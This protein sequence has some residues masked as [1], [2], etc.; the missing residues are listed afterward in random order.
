[1]K[2]RLRAL[3]ERG[4]GKSDVTF[5]SLVL[6]AILQ[7]LGRRVLVSAAP[8]LGNS[9]QTSF[10]RWSTWRGGDGLV[11]RVSLRLLVMVTLCVASTNALVGV[12]SQVSRPNIVF[13]L[14]DD[15]GY[16]DLSCQNPSSRIRTPRLDRLAGEGVRFTDAHAPSALCTPSRYSILTGQHCWRSRLKSGVANMWDEPL[17]APERMTVADLLHNNGYRTGFFGKWHLG[18]SWPFVGAVPD[19]FDINVTPADI[20]W[21]RRI[22]GGPVD[23]GFD[24]YFGINLANQPPYAFIENDHI[25]G[26]P[27]VQYP[28]ATGQQ[29]HWSG[30]GV[31]N[32]DWTQV[33]PQINSNTVR[34][35]QSAGAGSQPFFLYASLVGPHQPV[36]PSA[37]FQQTSQAGIYGDYV[38]EIDWAVGELLDALEATG[39]ATNT[40]VIFTSDNGPDEF[41]YARLQRYQHASMGELR[42]IKSDIWE[43]GHRVPFLARWPGQISGGTTNTQTICL[44]D[45]M[46]TVAD[47]LGVQLPAN[48][49]ED[50]AS[51]LSTLLGT[52]ANSLINTTHVTNAT[53][54]LES[55]IGQFGIRSNNWMYID[56]GTGDGHDPELEPLWFKQARQYQSSI[57]TP[58]LLYDL[59]ND[60][61]QRTNLLTAQPL[62]ASQL[63]AELTHQRASLSWRGGFS[64]AWDIADNWVPVGLPQGADILYSNWVGLANLNQTLSRAFS[65]NSI[66]LDTS[67]PADVRITAGSCGVLTIA[68]GIDMGHASVNLSIEAPLALS[69]SQVWNMG[70]GHELAVGGPVGIDSYRLTFCGSGNAR[71]TN[72][73]T[74]SGGLVIRSSGTT[75]LDARNLFTGG[76]E[77][78]GGGV[79][80]ARNN[81]A[82]GTGIL[83]IPN[84]STLEIDRGITLTNEA[85]VQGFGAKSNGVSC[86]AISMSNNGWAAYNGQIKLSADAALRADSPDSRLSIGGV[87]SGDANLTIMAGSGAIV[88][89]TNQSYTGKTLI[90]GQVELSGGPDRLPTGTDLVF[91]NASSAVLYLNGNNQTV[92]SISGGGG[93]GGNIVLGPATLTVATVGTSQYDGSISGSGVLEKTGPGKLVLCGTNTY[94]GRTGVQAGALT[95]DGVL[96][97]SGIIVQNGALSGYGTIQAP[98]T[99]A[100]GGVL[101]LPLTSSP[102]T[103]K[104]Q[105]VLGQ[106]GATWLELD[107]VRGR[108]GAVQGLT[109]TT[110]GGHLLVSNAVP[111]APFTNGQSFHVFSTVV[112]TGNFSQIDPAPGTGLAW[113]FDPAKGLLS[114]M[115]EPLLQFTAAA[116]RKWAHLTWPGQGF[117]LQALTNSLGINSNRGWADYPGGWASPVIIPID[118]EQ[119]NVFFRLVSP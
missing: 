77:L 86:G 60:I 101:A 3:K 61:A 25:V 81:G 63:Q 95:I 55:G 70:L 29:S 52:P 9:K 113:R 33:L 93:R 106:A 96:G 79:L 14:A 97:G 46:R 107:P 98:V 114:V 42:G 59:S 53:H 6:I 16:G 28:T 74:G 99:I 23:C 35:I 110:Y 71:I 7:K 111:A 116:G 24:Y 49:A 75:V 38:Q 44:I 76:I 34:W 21:T 45:L 72:T 73:I 8:S 13:I 41:A 36:V 91:S 100:A 115:A 47:M 54:V 67:V 66:I 4:S 90:E 117:H 11:C 56:S 83:S 103:L 89:A 1:M 30:P 68:G 50:S 15:L 112:A 40:L 17:I 48:A 12:A 84:N 80:K 94:T 102:L 88:F 82:L 58:A 108:C 105:L 19:G 118:P 65:V 87:I 64:A 39:A 62:I 31:P 22:G 85:V 2:N 109:S 69:Q 20:D 5:G 26:L 43:G 10:L 104:N 119:N 37:A 57:S 32:W 78:S 51:F 18:L 92:G 27:T